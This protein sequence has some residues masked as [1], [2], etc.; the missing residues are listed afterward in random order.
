MLT[1]QSVQA[2]VAG[3]YDRTLTWQILV[4]RRWMNPVST[5]GSFLVNDW[6]P[7]G[8]PIFVVV[9]FVKT[10]WSPWGSTP[11]PPYKMAPSQSPSD[12]RTTTYAL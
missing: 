4:G 1:V 10:Y 8:T 11:G 12:Q 2:D 7:R 6:V 9:L 5:C 3:S